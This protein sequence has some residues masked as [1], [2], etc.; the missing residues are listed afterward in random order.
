MNDIL[1]KKEFF[2]VT[3]THSLTYKLKPHEK[4]EKGAM[5]GGVGLQIH[6]RTTCK[7]KKF[8]TSIPV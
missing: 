5:S 8:K 1:K 7:S 4:M 6:S 3:S 2:I